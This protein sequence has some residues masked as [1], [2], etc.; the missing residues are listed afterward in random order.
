M[1]TKPLDVKKNDL[2]GPGIGNYDEL[3]NVLPNNYT[4]LLTPRETQLAI[5]ELKRFIEDG[6]SKELNLMKVEVVVC[7]AKNAEKR[8]MILCK[9]SEL[10]N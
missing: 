4:S 2:A 9:F 7:R 6:L 3:K 5:T 10:G 1:D 8:M